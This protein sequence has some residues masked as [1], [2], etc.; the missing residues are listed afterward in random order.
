MKCQF[1]AA[2][3]KGPVRNV[4]GEPAG[5]NFSGNLNR[6]GTRAKGREF[7]CAGTYALSMATADRICFIFR[8]ALCTLCPFLVHQ[9][10]TQGKITWAS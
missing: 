10:A 5:E 7:R 4:T 8:P 1:L 2:Y 3:A 9:V 6:A